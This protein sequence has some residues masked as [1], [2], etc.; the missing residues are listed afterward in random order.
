M[1]SLAYFYSPSPYYSSSQSSSNHFNQTHF[2]MQII[3]L[4][5]RRIFSALG[6]EF[7][8]IIVIFI[9]MFSIYIHVTLSLFLFP[10][11]ILLFYTIQFWSL[12]PHFYTI[13]LVV[14]EASSSTLAGENLFSM[15]PWTAAKK[16]KCLC[17]GDTRSCPDSQ[18]LA[19]CPEC[20]VNNVFRPMIRV[21]MRWYPELCIL[22]F[23]LQMRK[24]FYYLDW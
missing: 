24:T 22:A 3:L 4:I 8:I 14:H 2:S 5:S 17:Q 19:T 13:Y 16:A 11:A 10:L 20:R 18:T 23:T 21:I 1:S 9:N 12:H 6:R 7:Y 15:E